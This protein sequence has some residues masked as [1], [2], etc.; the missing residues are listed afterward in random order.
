MNIVVI[1]L[2]HVGVVAA[3]ALAAIFGGRGGLMFEDVI[4]PAHLR[5]GD[6]G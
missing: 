4:A 5:R 1:G 2:G 3:A 6:N